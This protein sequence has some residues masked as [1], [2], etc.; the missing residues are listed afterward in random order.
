MS[1]WIKHR[2]GIDVRLDSGAVMPKK[3]HESDAGFDLYMPKDVECRVLRARDSLTIDTGVHMMIPT[4]YVGMIKSKSGLNVKSGI[5]SEGVVDAGYSGSIVV[6]LY[7]DSGVPYEFKSGEKISQ[8]VILP[9]PEVELRLVEFFS[10]ET[11]RGDSGFGSS[12]RF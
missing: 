6:K 12:G 3:A 1:S 10:E 2:Q 7:N 8:I 9:V 11:E 5:R 4:G